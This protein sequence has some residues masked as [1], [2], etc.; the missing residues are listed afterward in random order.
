MGDI[1]FLLK[2]KSEEVRL[3]IINYGEK[4]K[5]EFVG[6]VSEKESQKPGNYGWAG[7]FEK[8]ET[9]EVLW[10]NYEDDFRALEDVPENKKVVLDHD[11]IYIHEDEACGGGFIFWKDSKFNWL[12]QE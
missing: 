10:S 6:D 3:C 12:Q 1:A 7:V 2:D 5:I 11:A 4:N 9:R 8:I